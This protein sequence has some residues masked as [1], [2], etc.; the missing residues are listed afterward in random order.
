MRSHAVHSQE[1]D[2]LS[3]LVKPFHQQGDT[4]QWAQTIVAKSEAV[5]E[6]CTHRV[7][8]NKQPQDYT[9]YLH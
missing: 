7:E 1:K 8:S 2:Q 3:F 6:Y 5:A 4:V 9:A